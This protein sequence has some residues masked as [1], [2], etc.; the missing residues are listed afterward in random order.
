LLSLPAPFHPLEVPVGIP[1]YRLGDERSLGSFQG[2][3]F[4]LALDHLV[5]KLGV[6]GLYR[7]GEPFESQEKSSWRVIRRLPGRAYNRNP[8]SLP[9]AAP[10]GSSPPPPVPGRAPLRS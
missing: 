7:F 3:R 1:F 8:T 5:E 2:R 6:E 9:A 4:R 10:P